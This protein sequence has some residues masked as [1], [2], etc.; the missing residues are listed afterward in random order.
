MSRRRRRPRPS[1][2]LAARAR[3]WLALPRVWAVL[4]LL[5]VLV[6]ILSLIAPVFTQGS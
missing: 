3:R 4:S 2:S 5:A 6:L 1:R